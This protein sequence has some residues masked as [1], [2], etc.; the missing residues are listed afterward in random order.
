MANALTAYNLTQEGQEA[1]ARCATRA[2]R[3]PGVPHDYHRHREGVWDDD[4]P[5]IVTREESEVRIIITAHG[6]KCQTVGHNK[7]WMQQGGVAQ[8]GT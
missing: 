6:A 8:Q 7:W 3:A 5:H 1:S 2:R 4:E